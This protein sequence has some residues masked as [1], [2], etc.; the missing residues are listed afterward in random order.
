MASR[1]VQDEARSVTVEET[2]ANIQVVYNMHSPRYVY[3]LACFLKRCM[4]CRR[5]LAWE[6]C[7]SQSVSLSVCQTRNLWQSERMM[8]PDFYTI[9]K[10]T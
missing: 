7:V 8:C 5:G 4:E 9:R 3:L 6:F 10:I 2:L 1:Q